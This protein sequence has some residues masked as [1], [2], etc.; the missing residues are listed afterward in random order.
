MFPRRLACLPAGLT[1]ESAGCEA[2]RAKQPAD[3]Q[4]SGYIPISYFSRFL[5][6][7]NP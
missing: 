7:F 6:V 1:A 3:D 5:S 2:Q 4:S